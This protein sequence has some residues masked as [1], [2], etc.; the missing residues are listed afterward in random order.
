MFLRMCK[1]YPYSFVYLFQ[2]GEHLWIGAT[3]ELLASIKNSQF[4]TV[5]LAATRMN[6]PENLDIS[7][8]SVKEREEQQY[9]TDYITEV[10]QKFELVSVKKTDTYLRKASNLLHLCNE[11]TCDSAE[12]NGKLTALLKELHP[13]PAVCGIPKE[14]VRKYVAEVELHDRQYYSGFLGPVNITNEQMALYVNLRCMRLY[15]DKS[16]LYVGGGITRD[17]LAADEWAETVLK[18]KTILSVMEED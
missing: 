4:R 13:T 2:A 18:A 1:K 6:I 10:L 3:P 16:I 5:S 11:F 15:A 7:G 8:W 9:V 14:D 12:I 17:S